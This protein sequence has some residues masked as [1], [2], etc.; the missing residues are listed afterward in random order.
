M[1]RAN[2]ALAAL[3]EVPEAALVGRSFSRTLFG[4]EGC[5]RTHRGAQGRA[6]RADGGATEATGRVLRLT[7]AP[8]ADRSAPRPVASLET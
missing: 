7:A 4:Q 5:R 6:Y 3:A 2:R 1:L 8:V